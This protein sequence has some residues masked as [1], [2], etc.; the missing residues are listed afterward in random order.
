MAPAQVQNGN[1]Y[2]CRAYTKEVECLESEDPCPKDDEECRKAVAERWR[3]VNWYKEQN[4]TAK[5][6]DKIKGPPEPK[7]WPGPPWIP[8][9][10]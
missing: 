5:K 2:E 6:E 7:D 4:C 3:R 8:K 1:A 9:K 10:R